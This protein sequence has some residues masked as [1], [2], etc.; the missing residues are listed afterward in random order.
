M[1]RSQR[2]PGLPT[3]AYGDKN[4][5][6]VCEITGCWIWMG[7]WN[8]KTRRGKVRSPR[9]GNKTV[10]A[11]VFFWEEANGRKVPIGKMLAHTC[12]NAICVNPK[13]LVPCES[14]ENCP[15]NRWYTDY[16]RSLDDIP[17]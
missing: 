13:H 11:Y 9:H 5:Y 4:K 12:E 14:F 7:G 2:E 17:F 15:V 3:F 8:T 16:Y 6:E 10:E 1:P